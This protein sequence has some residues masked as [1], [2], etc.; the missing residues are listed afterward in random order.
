L[1]KNLLSKFEKLKPKMMKTY[2]NI[3]DNMNAQVKKLEKGVQKLEN[4][5]FD[6]EDIIR[7]LVA[8]N[9]HFEVRE[10]YHNFFA[11]CVRNNF[12]L[13]S[14]FDDITLKNKL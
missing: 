9:E 3:L 5:Y 8:Y 1:K 10:I 12:D 11:Y 2:A 4:N 6:T 13:D 7:Y 14:E